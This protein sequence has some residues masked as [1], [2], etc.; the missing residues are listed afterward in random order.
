M[1]QGQDDLEHDVRV[2][3]HNC[4]FGADTASPIKRQNVANHVIVSC[5]DETNVTNE[6]V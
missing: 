4:D 6:E 1:F 5:K 3:V 2:H